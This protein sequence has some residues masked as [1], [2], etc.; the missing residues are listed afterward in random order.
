MWWAAELGHAAIVK[1]LLEKNA[2]L[3][4]KD[5]SGQTPLLWAAQGGHTA[6]VTLLLDRWADMS[7]E[8]K[9]GWTALQ[10]A[11]LRGYEDVE[12]LLVKHKS[13]DPEDFYGLE[14]LFS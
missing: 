11:A 7:I 10:L 4:A 8:N 2:E 12:R 1:L 3:E 6:T 5:N 9:S 14:K 13:P